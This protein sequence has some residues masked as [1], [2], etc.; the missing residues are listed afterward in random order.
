MN[1]LT[2]HL[3]GLF[4]SFTDVHKTKRWRITP[5]INLLSVREN[6]DGERFRTDMNAPVLLISFP[7]LFQEQQYMFHP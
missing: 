4:G 7:Q 1:Q 5:T 2:S 6:G 3:E